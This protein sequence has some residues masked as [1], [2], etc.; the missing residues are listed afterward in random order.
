MTQ[1]VMDGLEEVSPERRPVLALVP[2]FVDT[3]STPEGPETSPYHEALNETA[4]IAE[5]LAARPVR[6]AISEANGTILTRIGHLRAQVEFITS[7]LR[8]HDFEP[9]LDEGYIGHEEVMGRVSKLHLDER[10]ADI[11]RLD[12][13][14]IHTAFDITRRRD[15]MIL[16]NTDNQYFMAW[17][18]RERPDELGYIGQFHEASH[19]RPEDPSYD[20]TLP[21]RIKSDRF[22]ELYEEWWNTPE[23]VQQACIVD[24]TSQ[25]LDIENIGAMTPEELLALRGKIS[26]EAR[27]L[28]NGDGLNG[29]TDPEL[30]HLDRK[31][32]FFELQLKNRGV[33]NVPQHTLDTVVAKLQ[34]LVPG[35][36]MDT[37]IVNFV[38]ESGTAEVDAAEQ[39]AAA[40]AYLEFLENQLDELKR[41]QGESDLGQVVLQL[42]S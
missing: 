12:A 19:P 40:K 13:G 28:L 39:K 14:T 24:I 4:R 10:L 30:P 31:I 42:V 21:G 16:Y 26:R 38:V 5:A 15:R 8:A 11:S 34:H 36:V 25:K 32:D 35:T 23:S 27:G 3:D 37:D 2:K 41:K 18:I 20:N 22:K 1:L 6:K 7:N 29:W 33:A 9:P 17:V